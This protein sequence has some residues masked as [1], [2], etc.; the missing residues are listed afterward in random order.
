MGMSR[1]MEETGPQEEKMYVASV[2][3]FPLKW[4]SPESLKDKKFTHKSD[5][6][7]YGWYAFLTFLFLF[8][9]F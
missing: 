4:T 6:W 7:S 3:H 5:V 2:D 1:V 9:A 8:P